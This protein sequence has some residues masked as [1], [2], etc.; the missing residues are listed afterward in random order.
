MWQVW[1]KLREGW[2]Q[3]QWSHR[4][5]LCHCGVSHTALGFFSGSARTNAC[6]EQEW[7]IWVTLKPGNKVQE[8]KATKEPGRMG[9]T[10]C[11]EMQA[12][13]KGLVAESG[14]FLLNRTHLPEFTVQALAM[15]GK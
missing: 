1:S 15:Q 7:P 14:G 13:E 12:E 4:V 8:R 5:S 9:E 6:R 10:R 2:W 11:P 3:A